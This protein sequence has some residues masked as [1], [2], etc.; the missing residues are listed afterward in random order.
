MAGARDLGLSVE[1]ILDVAEEVLRKY[2]PAKTTVVDVAQ[3]LGVSHGSVYRYFESKAALRDAVA[4]RWLARISVPLKEIAES[5]L[6]ASERLVRWMKFLSHTKRQRALEDPALFATY[7]ALVADS[8]EVVMAH[9]DEMLEHL[10]RIL[11]DGIAQGIF[12][13][14]NVPETAR[15][16]FDATNRFHKPS[17]ASEW[18]DPAIEPAFDAVLQLI[19][20]GLQRNS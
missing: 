11:T 6:P 5:D 12:R 3:A 14:L 9:V 19:L 8:R 7:M 15:A 2:G 10:K 1:R 20:F 4:R 16:I 17:F 18:S 13:P